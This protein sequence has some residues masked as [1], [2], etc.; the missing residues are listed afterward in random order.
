MFSLGWRERLGRRG[1][2]AVTFALTLLVNYLAGY[3]INRVTLFALILA[4][5]LVVDDPDRGRRE[6]LPALPAA[7]GAAAGMRCRTRA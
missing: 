3:T 1:R 5:G 6:H 2:R 4:L 7:A